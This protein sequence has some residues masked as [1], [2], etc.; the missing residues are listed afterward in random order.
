MTL[1]ISCALQVI[2]FPN[3]IVIAL[4]HQFSLQFLHVDEVG[5]EK[6]C[7]KLPI[8]NK[9]IYTIS[10][11][12]YLTAVALFYHFLSLFITFL[13]IIEIG[14]KGYN[15]RTLIPPV[16]CILQILATFNLYSGGP[17]MGPRIS[18]Q[19]AK[20]ETCNGYDLKICYPKGLDHRRIN[21]NMDHL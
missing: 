19:S 20:G 16:P 5:E 8:T 2:K 4:L 12:I 1:D 13:H 9:I 21:P 17:R 3:E 6:N 14:Q 11:T 7:S 10:M 15:T 18:Q